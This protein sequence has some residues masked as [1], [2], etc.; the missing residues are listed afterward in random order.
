ME[1]YNGWANYET[2][3]LKLWLDEQGDTTYYKEMFE[4]NNMS[5]F[6][7]SETILHDTWTRYEQMNMSGFFSDMVSSSIRQVDFYE[8][9]ESIIG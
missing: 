1:K 5:P 8:I 3:N 6:E 7:L 4:E 2:W 9:A